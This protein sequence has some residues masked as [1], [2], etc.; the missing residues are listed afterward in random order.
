MTK[1]TKQAEE[2]NEIDIG[3]VTI[4]EIGLDALSKILHQQFAGETIRII[5]IKED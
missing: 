3:W 2:G 5:A 4:D 1:W